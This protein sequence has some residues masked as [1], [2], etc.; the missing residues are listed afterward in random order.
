M[1]FYHLH[2]IAIS[3]EN[4]MNIIQVYL[5]IHIYYQIDGDCRI[6]GYNSI[7]TFFQIWYF[8]TFLFPLALY[9]EL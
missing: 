1:I 6:Q 8:S 9:T 2:I 3:I 7:L 5:K 4:N